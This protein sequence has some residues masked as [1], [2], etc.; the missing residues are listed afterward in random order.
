[1][2]PTTPPGKGSTP[3]GAP[4]VLDIPADPTWRP[5]REEIPDCFRRQA[6]PLFQTPRE[7]DWS[8]LRPYFAPKVQQHL[9]NCRLDYWHRQLD[10]PK[11]GD[12]GDDA[13]PNGCS[14]RT[15]CGSCATC[16]ARSRADRQFE[17]LWLIHF[18]TGAPMLTIDFELP[19]PT[20]STWAARA[21]ARGCER[22]QATGRV[23]SRRCGYCDSVPL[24][25]EEA[26]RVEDSFV[27]RILAAIEKVMPGCGGARVSTCAGGHNPLSPLYTVTLHL[28]L[29]VVTN[30]GRLTRTDVPDLLDLSANVNR[31]TVAAGLGGGIVPRATVS[32]NGPGIVDEI[33]RSNTPLLAYVV[34]ELRSRHVPIPDEILATVAR[35]DL[36]GP[37]GDRHRRRGWFGS[38]RSGRMKAT[39]ARM[40]IYPA[41]IPPRDPKH[42]VDKLRPYARTTKGIAVQSLWSGDERVVPAKWFAAEPLLNSRGFLIAPIASPRWEFRRPGGGGGSR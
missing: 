4:F 36:P 1:M 16:Y 14:D 35:L 28:P 39:L 19:Q 42:I 21:A 10:T 30:D 11:G 18:A 33:W 34:R 15:R 31:R 5:R 20:L 17:I 2:A 22:A 24:W 26:R 6:I 3:C 27:E 32:H 12:L 25:Q 13:L 9:A 23:C 41:A 40:G 7:R 8:V 38:L 37:S 29:I